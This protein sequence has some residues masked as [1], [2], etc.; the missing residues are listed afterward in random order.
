MA[1]ITL[2]YL[3]E[4]AAATSVN[5]GDLLHIN[6]DGN[7][8]SLTAG[9]LRS[10][11]VNYIHPVGVVMLFAS[12]QNPNN[13]FQGTNWQRVPGYGRAIRLAS[14]DGTD[15]LQTGGSDSVTISSDN[16]PAHNHSINLSTSTFDHGTKPTT[17]NGLHQ[18][19]TS[20]RVNNYAN[21]TGGNDVLKTGSGEDFFSDYAGDHSH[22]TNIGPHSHAVSGYTDNSGYL[23][24][25]IS[26]KNQ[27]INL[28]AWYR[29]S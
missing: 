26:T 7:D 11:L 9:V 5:E 12:N 28:I 6:Q 16:I 17:T 8:R 25:P 23:N 15:V 22:T 29:I 24:T 1:D 21:S 4:L 13:L 20:H 14:E 19:K 3:T 2:K 10:F 27:Y 18:H